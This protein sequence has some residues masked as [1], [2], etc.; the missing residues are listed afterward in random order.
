MLLYTFNISHVV[1][2]IK[3]RELDETLNTLRWGLHRPNRIECIAIRYKMMYRYYLHNYSTTTYTIVT[4]I[5]TFI[6]TNNNN[7]PIQLINSDTYIKNVTYRNPGGGNRDVWVDGR[8]QQKGL[9]DE[10]CVFFVYNSIIY[11]IHTYGVTLW[12][13]LNR[14]KISVYFL[15]FVK[16][17]TYFI[18][19][20]S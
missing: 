2:K 19:C 16:F 20:L 15:I 3:R 18:L 5:P 12:Q 11:C 14:L 7:L 10:T 1:I 6:G 13:L 4:I 9:L 8:K 17:N